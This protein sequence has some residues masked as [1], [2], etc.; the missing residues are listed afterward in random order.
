MPDAGR[1]P[2][3]SYTAAGW[4]DG[5]FYS[6]GM[7][8]D[9]DRRQDLDNV[10]VPKIEARAKKLLKTIGGN[11]LKKHL[12]E[13][14]VLE[15]CC[16]AAR[17]FILGRWEAPL[18]TSPG[19][20]ARCLGC[21]SLQPDDTGVVSSQHRLGFTPTVEEILQIAVPH[22]EKAPRPVVSFGQGCEG[23][24]LLVGNLI[25]QS[26]HEIRRRTDRGI[27]NLNTNA[28]RPAVVERLAKAGLDSIRVSL[29]S[30]R[31]NFYNAYYRP[32]DYTLDDVFESIRI[33]RSYDRW[34]SL[35][36]LMFPGFSDLPDELNALLELVEKTGL[37][38]IQ[39]RNLNIDP[40]WYIDELGLW[41]KKNGGEP[42]GIPEWV[43]RLKK[44]APWVKLGYFNPPREE[45]KSEHYR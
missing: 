6:A 24:P 45:M 8:I 3:Y 36:Y 4:F 30:V 1:L 10:D 15:Y 5:E 16:P 29:N 34:V 9:S 35:N 7:R 25:E 32:V 23:E 12:I 2:L 13:H 18:P 17:N 21:I 22:L 14:C 43:A 20:N 33:M 28:S 40:E 11:R 31:K 37:N 41:D 19:C 38:M 42:V 26:I 27:I 39:T 44:S